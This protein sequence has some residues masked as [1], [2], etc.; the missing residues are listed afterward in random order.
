MKTKT[1]SKKIQHTVTIYVPQNSGLRDQLGVWGH[2]Q[3]TWEFYKRENLA[4]HGF[5]YVPTRP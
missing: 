4:A 5:G 2:V 1:N 3:V